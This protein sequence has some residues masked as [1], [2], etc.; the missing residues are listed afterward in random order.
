LAAA[1]AFGSFSRVMSEPPLC[2][3]EIL[4]GFHDTRERLTALRTAANRDLAGRAPA[5]RTE[6]EAI[7][8]ERT[9]AASIPSLLG[10]G[11]LPM[12]VAHNDAKLANLL[13]DTASPAVP[14]VIDLDTVMP[15]S[16]LHDFGDLVRSMVTG[17]AED[18]E[19]P[20]SVQVRHDYFAAIVRG[21]LAGTGTLLT[22]RERSLLVTAAR[23]IALE[24]AARFL[25]D[26]LDGDRYFPVTVEG[27]NLRRARTQLALFEG[28][29]RDAEH[30]ESIVADA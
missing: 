9:L 5:S 8:R 25:T 28:L 6:I 21:F 12:R 22:A 27:Q 24:Q 7:L 2:L 19:D 30:L 3:R 18:A 26:H 1:R 16:P 23:S 11:E 14:A 20:R 10:S 15:G 17:A 29:T 13:F 4:P